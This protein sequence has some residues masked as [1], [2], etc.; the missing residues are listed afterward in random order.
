MNFNE[1]VEII[2]SIASHELTAD[3]DNSGVQIY[4]GTKEVKSIL[5]ALEVTS[6]VIKEAA[7][8]KVD[9][10]ITHHPLFFSPL[11][12]INNDVAIGRFTIE[13][14]QAGISV[15]SVHTNFD[16]TNGGNND[17]LAY[18]LK[19]NNVRKFGDG[20]IGTLGE[21][22]RPVAF[23]DFC[24]FTK[25]TLKLN[26]IN[27][28]GAPLTLIKNIGICSGAGSGREM[29]DNAF[30]LGCDLYI[31]GDVKYHDAQYA[32]E[33]GIC[34]ID[35][36][37]YG[38]EKFFAENMIKQLKNAAIVD[39]EIISSKINADPFSYL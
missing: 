5:V 20:A 33:K 8:K 24:K 35:A 19:L 12:S 18:M 23:G 38:T 25:E 27:T 9:L 31:T 3:W 21:L 13:L 32:L 10:I 2:E 7:D 4:T 28:V 22:L 6:D 37:H 14:I 39:V 30:F 34:L 16:E 11:Y 15:Y 26:C 36:G 29:I 1:I 17:Y